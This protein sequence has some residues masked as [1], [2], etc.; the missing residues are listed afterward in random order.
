MYIERFKEYLERE[1]MVSPLTLRAYSDD[2]SAFDKYLNEIELEAATSSDCR[3]YVMSMIERGDN[4]RSVNRRISAL[5]K[6]YDYLIRS[7]VVEKNPTAKL[8]AMKTAKNLPKFVPENR[9][10]PLVD[11][12]MQASADEK[13]E[14][15]SI[16]MLLLYYCGLRRAE[17]A[18]ITIDKL[19]FEQKMLRI[20][21]KGSKE[22][23]VPLTEPIIERL[24]HYLQ[25]FKDKIWLT[26]QKSLIL[27][28]NGQPITHG[29]IY[30]IVHRTLTMA[31]I[32]GVRSPHVLRH[33]FATHLLQ[34]GA[35]IKTI[36]ELLGHS[37]IAST[38][39]YAHTTIEGLK[40]SY[41]NAHPRSKNK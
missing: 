32:D 7:G 19:D 2:L 24:E 22:Q 3:G 28:D 33:S 4:P 30:E 20:L 26:P 5:R 36:A 9:M 31:G 11:Q 41:K 10:Q 14:R 38:E 29:E 37:S 12:M 40:E 27:G 13:E 16:V 15:D 25:L 6:F 39:I 1:L 18:T 8:H 21:G 35:P 17:L 34:R 23:I